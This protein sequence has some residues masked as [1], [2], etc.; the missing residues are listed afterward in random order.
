MTEQKN[1]IVILGSTG[2]IGRSTLS[3]IR[4]N[5]NLFNV[6]GLSCEN[7]VS[8]L[9]EQIDEFQQSNVCIGQEKA[10]ELNTALKRKNSSVSVLEG[11]EG[12][13]ELAKMNGDILVAA[14]VGAA[15][16]EPVM[17]GIHSHKTIALANK[18][19]IVLAGA[20]VMEEA[21]RHNVSILPVDSEHNAIYQ[22]L[23]DEKRKTLS[24]ITLTASGGPF[25]NKPLEEFPA[26]T[27]QEALK[28]PNWSMGKKITI[29]SA[30]MMNKCL[31]IIEAKWLFDI[32]PDQIKVVI[33][34]QSIIHSMVSFIDSSTIAQL[35]LPDMR[36]PIAYCLGFPNRI[37]SG[38]GHLD[39]GEIGT[40]N[41]IKP[42][43]EKFP[44]LGF[45][46]DVLRLG[47]GA[48]A[49]LN[50][51][52]EAL[53]DLFLNEKISFPEISSTLRSLVKELDNNKPIEITSIQDAIQADQWGR[54]FVSTLYSSK[55]KS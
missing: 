48:P 1:D 20:I 47:G 22:C 45:A 27:L 3:V 53:V 54:K 38:V 37:Q 6:V 14:I 44:T 33:H 17:A 9:L 28:H 50:G 34:P 13:I 16:M 49:A 51:A 11:P 36:T 43:L 29:D 21:R 24:F 10:G 12:L 2:S 42:D 5:P 46:Y 55:A 15:G 18:E 8:L 4:Q 32:T 7:N 52:N 39:L 26:I 40:L 25:Y 30:T 31:E 35:G 19:S 23:K 41:F